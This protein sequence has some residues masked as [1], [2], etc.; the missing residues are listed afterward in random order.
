MSTLPEQ[1]VV[2]GFLE[3]ETRKIDA[4]VAMIREGTERLKEY[5]MTLISAAVRGKIDVRGEAKADMAC[6][7]FP[8]MVQ[9]LGE[10]P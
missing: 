4:M 10:Y 8:V 1:D 2:G 6:G 9:S 3:S 5:R 7:Y